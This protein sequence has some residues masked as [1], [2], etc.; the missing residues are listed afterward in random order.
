M[1]RTFLRLLSRSL[2]S[3]ANVLLDTPT[4]SGRYQP[5][6]SATSVAGADHRQHSGAGIQRSDG[7]A[8]R[9]YK[10]VGVQKVAVSTDSS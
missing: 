5:F 9:F 7:T 6:R 4:T 2:H 8:A 1:A 3:E 10:S